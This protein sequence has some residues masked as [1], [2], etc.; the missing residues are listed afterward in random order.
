MQRETA[1]RRAM[2]GRLATGATVVALPTTALASEPPD[3]HAAWFAEWQRLVDWCDGPGPG[4]RDLADCPEWH[5]SYEVEQ[6]I[7]S[8]PARTLPGALCQLRM[9]RYYT[10]ASHTGENADMAVENAIT[11]L[12]QLAGGQAHG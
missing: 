12:A 5:R 10:S 7:A 8:T 11:S 3:P 9:A 6:L 4:A 1:N 2:L